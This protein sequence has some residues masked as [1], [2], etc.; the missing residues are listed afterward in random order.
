MALNISHIDTCLSCYLTDHHNRDG[1]YLI[2]IPVNGATTVGEIAAELES[3]ISGAYDVGFP[4]SITDEVIAAAILEE[5][6]ADTHETLFD[7]S[8]ETDDSLET[9]EDGDV[10][11]AWFLVTWDSD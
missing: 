8:L 5:L 1:E 9:E 7:V 2:G 10:P 11:Q 4:D 6:P 3:E